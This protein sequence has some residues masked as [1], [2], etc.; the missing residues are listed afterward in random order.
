MLYLRPSESESVIVS[1]ERALRLPLSERDRYIVLLARRKLQGAR[2]D[3]DEAVR[4]LREAV[5]ESIPAG[6]VFLLGRPGPAP[7]AGL[8]AASVADSIA[9]PIIGSLLSGVGI[10]ESRDGV[11]LLRL[12]RDGRRLDLGRFVP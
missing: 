11:R 10:A 4:A 2:V 3:F 8:A 1:R 7:S 5:E 6:R 9:G 12:T